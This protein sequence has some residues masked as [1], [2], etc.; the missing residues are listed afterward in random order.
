MSTPCAAYTSQACFKPWFNE[1]KVPFFSKTPPRYKGLLDSLYFVPCSQLY[2]W[3]VFLVC[4]VLY[5]RFLYLNLGREIVGFFVHSLYYSVVIGVH[6][7]TKT[8]FSLTDFYSI[9]IYR[10][11]KCKNIPIVCFYSNS[12]MLHCHL[13]ID[14]L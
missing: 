11:S 10:C 3:N 4:F 1:N 6:N 7:K 2:D 14:V 12:H 13:R 5:A 9:S 8:W